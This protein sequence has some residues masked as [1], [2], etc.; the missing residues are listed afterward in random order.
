M[1]FSKGLLQ[2]I[3]DIE[4]DKE[5]QGL[6]HDSGKT[7]LINGEDRQVVE[8]EKN[9]LFQTVEE[10]NSSSRKYLK[11]LAIFG[12]VVIV[13]GVAIAYFTLPRLGDVVRA[14]QGLEAA[15]R[16]HFLVTEKR[17]STDI[18]FYYCETFYWARVGV[19]KRPDI[20]TNPV[21]QLD[22]YKAHAEAGAGGTWAI[23]ATPISSPEMD[24]PCR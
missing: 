1:K 19:E 24:T 7:G 4:P 9:R 5:D 18:T 13:G 14:P 21:Y 3:E 12:C 11:M 23:T 2:D 20:K 8:V 6:V 16:D 17:T 15:V 22:T 10:K